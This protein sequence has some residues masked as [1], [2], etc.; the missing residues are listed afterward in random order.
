M[1]D[2]YQ[3]M[4]E[5]DENGLSVLRDKKLYFRVKYESHMQYQVSKGFL[6]FFYDIVKYIKHFQE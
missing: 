2:W 4:L 6:M 5:T 1:G 3:T